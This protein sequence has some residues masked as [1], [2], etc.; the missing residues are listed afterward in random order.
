[1]MS[2]G[3]C[4]LLLPSPKSSMFSL[5]IAMYSASVSTRLSFYHHCFLSNSSS[6]YSMVQCHMLFC[7]E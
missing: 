7:T 2:G 1:M 5:S 6:I 4:S 3:Y